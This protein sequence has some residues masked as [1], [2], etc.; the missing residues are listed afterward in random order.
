LIEQNLPLS[1]A[2]KNTTQPTDDFQINDIK[3][4]KKTPANF[5]KVF[6]YI[7]PLDKEI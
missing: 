5:I 7:K 1:F 6:G 4:I 2:G 3:H